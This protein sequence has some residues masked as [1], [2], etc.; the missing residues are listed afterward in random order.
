ML[1]RSKAL[2]QEIRGQ[3]GDSRRLGTIIQRWC[4]AQVAMADVPVA[5]RDV[6]ELDVPRWLELLDQ[7]GLE[8]E[9]RGFSD[10]SLLFHRYVCR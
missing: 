6:Y 1:F 8:V 4:L 7:V 10:A 3:R 5:E 9:S 2:V